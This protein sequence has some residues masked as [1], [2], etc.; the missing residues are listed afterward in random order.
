[1]PLDQ[2]EIEE[3]YEQLEKPVYN[4]IYRWVWDSEE[5]RDIVQETFIRL[6]RIR[7]KVIPETVQPLIYRIALNLAANRRRSKRIWRW[8]TLESLREEQ[9]KN[10]HSRI[11]YETIER[12]KNVRR[13]VNALPEHL[14][15]VVLLSE[16]SELKYE[17]IAQCLGIPSGTVASRRNKALQLLH[18]KL[19]HIMDESYE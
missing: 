2:N 1:M 5:A 6:W 15:R 19:A 3:L 12:D 13:A 7:H 17:Q 11:E 10:N 9:S 8:V 4:V 14:K 18:K 16:F